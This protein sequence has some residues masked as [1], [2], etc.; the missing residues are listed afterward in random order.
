MSVFAGYFDAIFDV[1]SQSAGWHHAV[2]AMR[3]GGRF[4]YE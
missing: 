3:C 2:V 4:R 1:I